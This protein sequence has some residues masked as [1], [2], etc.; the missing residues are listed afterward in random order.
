ML[1]KTTQVDH[2]SAED[3]TRTILDGVEQKINAFEERLTSK[4]PP[5]FLNRNQVANYLGISL[6]TVHDWS[7]KGILKPYKIGNRVRYRREDIIATLERSRE[8]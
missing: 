6:P 2:V 7:K 4:E 1:K 3:L 8:S 5:E